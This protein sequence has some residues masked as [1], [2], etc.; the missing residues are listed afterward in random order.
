[1]PDVVPVSIRNER[2]AVLRNLS[3]QKMLAFT[4][5]H[6]GQNRPVLFESANKNGSMEGYT[7]N[8]IKV[9]AMFNKEWENKIID[10]KL[11]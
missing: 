10:W 2:N 6:S 1:M 5:L 4:N 3:Y 8:Y 9:S 7:D 11:P